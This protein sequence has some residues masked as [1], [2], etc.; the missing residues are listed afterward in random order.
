MQD[1]EITWPRESLT[2][3]SET[4]SRKYKSKSDFQKMGRDTV[5]K[6]ISRSLNKNKSD[7]ERINACYVL[8]KM[9][10]YNQHKEKTNGCMN[11]LLKILSSG[12]KEEK[13]ACL[14]VMIHFDP[15][16]QAS[17]IITEHIL[18]EPDLSERGFDVIQKYERRNVAKLLKIAYQYNNEIANW[19]E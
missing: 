15:S 5:F 2:D 3:D 17:K 7:N 16:F 18:H 6:W 12:D 13:M 9:R 1:Y 4:F 8:Q 11:K 19:M 10:E 14:D